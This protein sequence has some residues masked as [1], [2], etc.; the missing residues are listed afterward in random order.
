M[1]QAGAEHLALDAG[2][3]LVALAG[4]GGAVLAELA[5][6]LALLR[7]LALAL[8]ALTAPVTGAQLVDELAVRGDAGLVTCS[9]FA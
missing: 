9:T 1:E 6:V 5:A 2:G 8:S 3:E 4:A 7:L